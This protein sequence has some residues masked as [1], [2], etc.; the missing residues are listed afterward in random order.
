[1][2]IPDK[3]NN[4]RAYIDTPELANQIVGVTD[5]ITLPSFDFMSETLSLAGMAGEVDSPA[6]GQLQSVSIEL[7]FS[8]I[9]KEGMKFAQSDNKMLILR[10][11]QEMTDSET[12]AKSYI[13]RE[14]YI[15]GL[16]KGINYGTL[17]RL[18]LEMQALPK[19]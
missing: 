15:R 2:L 5:E 6:V 14:I 9:S 8:N 11:A 18:A 13:G 10:A 19:R 17:K 12:N 3:I 4:F 1:M 7:T 16:T